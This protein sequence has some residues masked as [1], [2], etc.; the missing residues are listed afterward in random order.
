MFARFL[1][2]TARVCADDERG[3]LYF[4]C[5]IRKACVNCTP[6]AGLGAPLVSARLDEGSVAQFGD[7]LLQLGLRVHD[8]RTVPGDRLLDRLVP[9][10]HLRN[11]ALV[12]E[13]WLAALDL[14]NREE[15][16]PT[17]Q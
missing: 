10:G 17:G 6:R 16:K 5:F 15:Y 3:F 4:S 9:I 14:K 12:R 11:G 8:D 1:E 13:R 7:R 2:S